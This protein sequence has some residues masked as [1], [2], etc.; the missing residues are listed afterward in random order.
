MGLLTRD[1]ERPFASVE[2]GVDLFVKLE[3]P[4]LGWVCSRQARRGWLKAPVQL[5]LCQKKMART[6]APLLMFKLQPHLPQTGSPNHEL[7]LPP[8][9]IRPA[10]S[11][12]LTI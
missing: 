8:H 12:V 2:G 7:T 1:L 3:A 5:S 4:A 6:A 9:S 10:F 11:R